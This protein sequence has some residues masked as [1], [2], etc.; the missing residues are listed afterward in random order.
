MLVS[1]TASH[2]NAPFELLE[3]LSTGSSTISRTLAERSAAVRGSV[4]VST[5]N[6]FELYVDVDD[7]PAAVPNA[8]RAAAEVVSSA[9][10]VDARVLGGT[11]AVKTEQDAA[12]HLFAVAAG[13]ESVVV[14]EG[15]IAGQVRRSLERARSEG[16]TTATLERLFQRASQTSRGVKN[17]TPI[18]R[19]GRSIVRLG[20]DLAE[21]RVADWAS[22]SVLLIGTGAY[23]GASLAALRER[24][25]TDVRVYSPSGRGAR[26]AANHGIP[27][28]SA[29]EYASA[30][31][32]A[33]VIVTCTV[34]EGYVLDA[35]RFHESRV[36]FAMAHQAAHVH[37]VLRRDDTPGCP[38]NHD[39]YQLVI[40]LGL[41]RNVDPDVASVHGVELLDLETIRIHAPLEELQA[42]DTARGIVSRAART[43]TRV[44]QE[45]SLAP[46]VVALRRR[47]ME[48]LEDEIARVAPN[49]PDGTA[50]A[51]LRHMMGRLLHKP[52]TRARD[53]ARD[54]EHDRYL[55]ALETLFGIEV[56][57]PDAAD[58]ASASEA[59]S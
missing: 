17:R 18:G 41:P 35:R 58:D 46:A 52:T 22:T 24:G 30:V 36:A 40:D 57:A 7:S 20:L 37:D 21:S 12:E 56:E 19:A 54:G 59:A 29:D 14:G 15:E 16:T 39:A 38:V 49:D 45:E 42:T 13:L 32:A 25:V 55:E 8:C 50:A 4:L 2:K 10:G 31:A 27:L 34:V 6:R 43:F 48:V 47:A 26:F 28:V 11:W 3:Q 51:A 5:C 53:Y 44:G 23:A 33:G 1:L 9:S